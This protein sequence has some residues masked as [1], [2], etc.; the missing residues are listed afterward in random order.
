MTVYSLNEIQDIKEN[1]NE[2]YLENEVNETLKNLYNLLGLSNVTIKQKPIKKERMSTIEN[3]NWK[4]QEPFKT[5]V[6]EKKEGIDSLLNNLRGVLN[7]IS[8]KN[9]LEQE[10][11]IQK[12]INKIIEFNETDEDNIDEKFNKIFN[13][14]Y[15]VLINNKVHSNLYAQ[16]FNFLCEEYYQFEDFMDILIRRYKQSIEQI[17]YIDPDEDYD[18]YCSI[19][20]LNEERKS[21]YG[22]LIVISGSDICSFSDIL[23]INETLF[24]YLEDNIENVEKQNINEEIVENISVFIKEG[25][26]KILKDVSKYSIEQNLIKYSELKDK[27]KIGFSTR[28]RFKFMDLVEYFKKKN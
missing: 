20:K 2:F 14:F 3:S 1:I 17:E 7:K 5:T 18:K 23:E 22:F 13:V 21:L 25:K 27:S 16:L 10:E 9:Y 11:Q 15:R 24:S 12:I 19:N 26:E 28:M 6:F 8:K 4:K